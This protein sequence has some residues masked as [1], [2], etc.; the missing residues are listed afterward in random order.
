MKSTK[1]YLIVAI[2]LAAAIALSLAILPRQSEIALMQM[3]DKR[4]AEALASY[5]TQKA[6]G[7]LSVD[8]AM[9][10][11]ELYLQE[12]NVEK[13]ILVMEEFIA[14]NPTHLDARKRLGT[15]YQYAQRSDDYLRNLE[16]INR[17][18]PTAE[19]LKTL[20]DIY[21]FTSEYDKQVKTLQEIISTES[22]ST[23]QH[24]I[25]LANIQAANKNYAEAIETLKKF[26]TQ[27]PEQF[28]F[29]ATMLLVSLMLDE[30]QQTEALQVATEWQA[31]NSSDNEGVAKLINMLHYKGS[32]ESASQL[33]AKYDDAAIAA[34]PDLLQEKILIEIATGREERVYG[35]LKEL[36]ASGKMAP[37]LKERL[38]YLAMVRD[39]EE[40]ATTVLPD[41][42]LKGLSEAQLSSLTEL[43]MLR[44]HKAMLA[45]LQQD[46]PDSESAESRPVLAAILALARG[47]K[48]TKEKLAVL[49]SMDIG[50]S[51]T[52]QIARICAR[53]RNTACAMT[54]LNKL[55]SGEETSDNDVASAAEIYL[56][57][58][59]WK[60]AGNLLEQTKNRQ[61]ESLESARLKYAAATGDNAAIEKWS[62]LNNS[63]ANPR[64][65]A[66]MFFL[67]NN[68]GHLELATII[69]ERFFA[70]EQSSL[71]R[72]CLSQAYVKTGQYEEALKLLR[73]V[74]PRTPDDESNYLFAL[75]KLS[76]ASEVYRKELSE[77]AA[78][79]LR[80][81]MPR[82]EKM[83]LVYALITAK[84]VEPA[85]PY[86]RELALSEG[87][88]WA[89]LYAETLD[90][91]GNHDEAR[92]FWVAYASQASTPKKD[93]ISV[94]YT[95]L[96]NGYKSD[97]ETIL[98]KMAAGASA[99]SEETKAL[100]Y[101]WGPRPSADK[102]EW[103]AGR[104]RTAEGEERDRWAKVLSDTTTDET[105][106]NLAEASPDN[107][108]SPAIAARYTE[109][110]ARQGKLAEEYNTI[111]KLA[112]TQGRTD[113]LKHYA[114]ATRD[115]GM[116]RESSAAYDTLFELGQGNVVMLR[117]AGVTAYNQAD[118]SQT[119]HYLNQYMQTS[120]EE[121]ATDARAYEA[122]YIYAEILRRDHET[123]L[124]KDYYQLALDSLADAP[125]DGDTE[126][127]SRQAQSLIWTDR[128]EEGL[129]A[130]RHGMQR[131]PQD[132][133]LR[134]DYANT[135]I[136][137]REYQQANTTLSNPPA[138][139]FKTAI[140]PVNETLPVTKVQNYRL[141]NGDTELLLF[142]N[143]GENAVKNLAKQ[144]DG[145]K[146]IG[147]VNEGY[148][149]LL[150]AAAP[151][152][153]FEVESS[154]D[155]VEIHTVP[156]LKSQ[157]INI[158]R[159]TVLRYE[160]L[161]ARLELETG[162]V[163]AASERLNNLL[164]QYEND[165]Q[166][167]GFAANA[168]NYGGN[169]PRAQALLAQAREISP[170]N[171]DIARLDKD[172]RRTYA[173]GAKLDFEWVS[174]GNDDE[175][176]TTAS[177]YGYADENLL[178]G[179]IVQNN[180]VKAKAE[181][182]ADGR[183]GSFSDDRQRGELY[184][185]YSWDLGNFLKGSL[186]ANNDTLGAGGA[187]HFLNALGETEIKADYHRPYWD[188]VASVLDDTTRD[189]IGF[190]H[191]I[192]PTPYLSLSGGPGYARYNVDGTNNIFSAATLSF[193][194][195]YRL[196]EAQPFM[197]VSYGF[198]AEYETSNK[199][200]FDNNGI[201]SQLGPMRSRELHFLALNLGYDFTA[202]TYGDL[203]LGYGY[204]RL[205]G[206]GPSV[207]G[208][209]THE[210][211]E[212]VDA[213]IRAGYGLDSG[214][215]DDNVT[216]VGAYLRW[217]Y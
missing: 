171:E 197:A 193:A 87:G 36:H 152:S 143:G 39:D 118:Y 189:F 24:F 66:D 6:K 182:L 136:E 208:R 83:A 29:D 12:S 161:T 27:Y 107:I 11:S 48:S 40:T 150:I 35:Q 46:F 15:F 121:R 169:W 94:A 154:K 195:V 133:I 8:V 139:T 75:A 160:L 217:K 91:Q 98:T 43:A 207:E 93:K 199:K 124:M 22:G 54:F 64:L 181:R 196:M 17:L 162:K 119:Y 100:V 56:E 164:P 9:H 32:V 86:I 215:S 105:I 5:E 200:G 188:Y 34:S 192:K 114:R 142:V 81:D 147:Y 63:S 65:M 82:K 166:L 58:K 62:A 172:I 163:H 128:T 187:W 92:E 106:I 90:K 47:D 4:F 214:Q 30:K 173:P 23:P 61:S 2:L 20:S 51:S 184:G 21:N 144:F 216:R 186:F 201:Y 60:E 213:Q 125:R 202:Y 127:L 132:D 49:E 165:A 167:L 211:T 41:V 88:S 146:G 18:T 101:L 191:T 198:D 70:Q 138:A 131:F 137:V 120:P 209:L 135:L 67:A 10:L 178:F 72:T 57:L 28:N 123:K 148:D 157:E 19:N 183:V 108:A 179:I 77:Y 71:S 13:A 3:K 134:A 151:G 37:V 76:G 117:E 112:R 109:A 78:V 140:T 59:A 33:M 1:P 203:I 126:A 97:A 102:L 180:N 130:F 116:Y 16:E 26:K 73:D 122:Y 25:D 177:G 174:R 44:D 104:M 153:K 55:P 52:M 204:D 175:Y 129:A 155:A 158:A 145:Q 96:G 84:Q 80:S 85:M 89:S 212:S 99:N 31:A 185:I 170:A 115:A 69:A 74:S 14:A 190:D 79:K 103:I 7:T 110:L 205:G 38:L 168:E 111:D 156:D 68:N 210:L 194:A 53:E 50:N 141:A 42:D 95:L 113:L 176:I 149:T 206:H 159:Q 45:R